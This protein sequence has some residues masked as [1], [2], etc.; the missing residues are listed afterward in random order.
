LSASAALFCAQRLQ[1]GLWSW[2]NAIL[3]LEQL[4]RNPALSQIAA[5]GNGVDGGPRRY[6]HGLRKPKRADNAVYHATGNRIRRL[7]IRIESLLCAWC[8]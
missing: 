6:S 8:C 7:P 4:R 1:N 5:D 3:I 2:P